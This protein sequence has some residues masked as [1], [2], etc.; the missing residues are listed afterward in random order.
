MGLYILPLSPNDHPTT[1]QGSPGVLRGHL[2]IMLFQPT[3][4]GLKTAESTMV[5]P[6]RGANLGNLEIELGTL[7]LVRGSIPKKKVE[8][9]L[10]LDR[11]TVVL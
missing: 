9:D 1:A 10:G 6:H 7:S 3:H 4:A 2:E 5:G 11:C 8:W